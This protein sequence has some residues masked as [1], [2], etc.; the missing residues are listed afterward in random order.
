M[1]EYM[2]VEAD[3][4]QHKEPSGPSGMVDE[5]FEAC[6]IENVPPLVVDF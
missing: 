4:I 1:W 2:R 3:M 6:S 5:E